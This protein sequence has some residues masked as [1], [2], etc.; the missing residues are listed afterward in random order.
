M[1]KPRAWI[2]LNRPHLV[3][4]E[5][6]QQQNKDIGSGS[7]NIKEVKAVYQEAAAFLQQAVGM[8]HAAA[9]EHGELAD[10]LPILSGFLNIEAAL[11]RGM[12]G[13]NA[14]KAV[15]RS[16]KAERSIR[17]Q[18]QQMARKAD[19]KASKRMSKAMP[20]AHGTSV[21]TRQS[22]RQQQHQQH[23]PQYQQHLQ[24][25]QQSSAFGL[26]MPGLHAQPRQ[27]RHGAGGRGYVPPA[28]GNKKG[29]QRAG[30]PA[31]H[32]VFGGVHKKAHG[33]GGMGGAASSDRSSTGS[34]RNA[35][36]GGK[37]QKG[38]GGK[39]GNG[40]GGGGKGGGGRGW[41][42]ED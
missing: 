42:H 12:A 40:K 1:P 29:K 30:N 35:G 2:Q 6:P 15:E 11:G 9:A 33:A 36:R 37:G 26:Q 24:Y 31:L 38:K 34:G 19:K 5:D 25:L 4:V 8:P 41:S 27:Q 20:G 16:L 10:S 7:H 22:R 23:Y 18:Q 32:Q 21:V 14:R 13:V 39:H 28:K 3:A 17:Q